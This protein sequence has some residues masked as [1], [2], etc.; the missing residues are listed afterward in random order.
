[1]PESSDELGPDY[2]TPVEKD[3]SDDE[4]QGEED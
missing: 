2:W 1:M 3:W 4:K